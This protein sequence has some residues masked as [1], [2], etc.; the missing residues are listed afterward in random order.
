MELF[1]TSLFM[2]GVFWSFLL[3]GFLLSLA[4]SATLFTNKTYR[5]ALLAFKDVIS[6]DPNEVLSAWND[7]LHFCMWGGVTSTF[8]ATCF[9]WRKKTSE[10][11]GSTSSLGNGFLEVS[12]TELLKATDGFLS[13][14]LIG[15]CSYG[16]VYERFLNGI[17]STV[18][19]KVLNLE[20]QRA[21]KSFLAECE[22]LRSI[23][24]QNIV[25]ILTVYSSIDFRG[26]DFKALVFEYMPNGSLNMWLHPN[27]TEQ[28]QFR[29]LSLIERLNVAIDV[30]CALNYLHHH[31]EKPVVHCD[32]KPSN[33]LLDANTIAHA[34]D[35]G[36][37]RIVHKE[38]INYSKTPSS[39]LVVE[40]SIG[41]VPPEYGTSRDPS[42]YG[43]VYSYGILRLEMLIGKRPIDDIFKDNL[44]LHQYAKMMLP[45]RV[46]EI[47]DHH[48]LIGGIHEITA[49]SEN[50]E[51]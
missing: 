13:N 51:R 26:N 32:L 2:R 47:I 28:H 41:Y 7:S 45:E 22:F 20:H 12:Y 38:V 21:S 16:F 3:H 19:I 42:T 31:C 6:D 5:L 1:H 33:I 49:Q 37:A 25:K 29:N 46:M 17:R 11:L 15:V 8:L 27:E 14:N 40:G 24:H 9:W 30:T 44:S 34:S 50:N 4:E 43:N 36:L 35:F 18:A 10:N 48:L 23:R 39:S